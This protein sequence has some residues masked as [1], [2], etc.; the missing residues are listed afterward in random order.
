MAPVSPYDVL[1][2]YPNLIGYARIAAA[3]A[4][5]YVANTNWRLSAAFYVAAFVGDVVD[6]AV[7]R[8]FKQCE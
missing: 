2:Y 3:L 5:Y 7:A 6:G 8:R 4:S 1:L